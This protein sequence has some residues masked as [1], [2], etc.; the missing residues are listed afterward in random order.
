MLGFLS[1][2]LFQSI[3]LLGLAAALAMLQP[4]QRLET[5]LLSLM[6]SY[7]VLLWALFFMRIARLVLR[8]MAAIEARFAVVRNQTLPLFENI[9]LLLIIGLAVYLV[10]TAW[11]I[12]M[13]AW[14]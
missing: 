14:L 9:A 2:P 7:A 6:L 8:K 11:H 10:F 12:D 13:T 5:L 1:Q 3:M 4:A